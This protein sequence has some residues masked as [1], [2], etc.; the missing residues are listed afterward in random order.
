MIKQHK[1]LFSD[2]EDEIDIITPDPNYKL[3]RTDTLVLFGL[4]EK[5][6]EFRR[7]SK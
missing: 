1:D 6:E 4:D 2:E 3:K 5:I 7:L